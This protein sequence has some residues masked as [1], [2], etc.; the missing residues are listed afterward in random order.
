MPDDPVQLAGADV[1]QGDEVAH[2][3]RHAPVVVLHAQRLP[4]ARRQLIDKA[5]SAI[6]ATV[7]NA[8]RQLAFKFQAQRLVV[9][10]FDPV[11]VFPSIP[12]ND[13]TDAFFAA[14]RLVVH[15]IDYTLAVDRNQSVAGFKPQPLGDAVRLN[16]PDPVIHWHSAPNILWGFHVVSSSANR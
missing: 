5:K 7:A 14:Q 10:L 8:A 6:V 15:K 16:A 13:Q 12:F 4:R 11:F 2:Q 3:Q 9:V 1:G